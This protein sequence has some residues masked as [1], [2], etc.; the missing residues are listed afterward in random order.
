M[1]LKQTEQQITDGATTIYEFICEYYEEFLF[2]PNYREIAYEF[3][4][5]SMR[6]IKRRMNN[7]EDRGLIIQQFH[8]G[9]WRLSNS[10]M[11]ELAENNVGKNGREN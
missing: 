1:R 7:L 5:M 8:G 10:K 2:F 9:T 3:G 11:I 4:G 6:E